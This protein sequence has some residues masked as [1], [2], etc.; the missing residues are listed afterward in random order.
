MRAGQ[1]RSR[2]AWRRLSRGEAPS[3]SKADIGKQAQHLFEPDMLFIGVQLFALPGQKVQIVRLRAV[4]RQLPLPP[5]GAGCLL[6][7][8][9]SISRDQPVTR[10][11]GRHVS[12]IRFQPA[13]LFRRRFAL[14]TVLLPF[15]QSVT[16][17][18]PLSRARF[19]R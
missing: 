7:H 15:S 16:P 8:N 4:A 17:R 10:L 2:L 3:R 5:C 13:F 14:T 18:L 1:P 6:A 9:A 19:P 11:P 12:R